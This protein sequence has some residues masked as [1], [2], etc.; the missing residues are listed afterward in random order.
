MNCSI[1]AYKLHW[2]FCII[3]WLEYPLFHSYW[4]SFINLYLQ[5]Y[6]PFHRNGKKTFLKFKWNHKR[7]WIVKTI[8]RKKWRHHTSW[9]QSESHVQ[10]FVISWTIQSMDSPGKN[11]GVGNH[12]IHWGNL[13]NPG[14]TPRSL[15][16]QVDSLPAETP[17]KP[18]SNCIKNP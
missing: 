18:T 15:T 2:K 7:P 10:L 12:S 14:I 11:T 9:L 1:A 13:L 3:M 6:I 5:K 4:S 16:L 17:G 8:W